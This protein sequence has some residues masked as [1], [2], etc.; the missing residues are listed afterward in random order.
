MYDDIIEKSSL[1]F[2]KAKKIKEHRF[3]FNELLSDLNSSNTMQILLGARGVGKTVLLLQLG[4]AKGNSFYLSADQLKPS[5]D[6]FQIVKG[7]VSTLKLKLILIDEIH[8]NT[9]F[10]KSL[11]AIADFLDVSV[12]VTSSSALTLDSSSIDLSR[13]IRIKY[14][15]PFCYREFLFFKKGVSLPALSLDDLLAGNYSSRYLEYAHYFDDYLRGGLYPFLLREERGLDVFGNILRKI[16]Y[17][18]IATVFQLA[19]SELSHIERLV[20][21]IGK[22]SVDGINITSLSKNLGITKYKA[23][24]YVTALCRT[25]VLIQI[26][27]AGANVL[28]EPKI[29]MS[30]P[31]RQLYLA[32]DLAI[33]GTREDIFALWMKAAGF[34]SLSYLKSTRGE[35]TPD[36]MIED[37]THGP[38]VIEIGGKGKGRSQFKGI[39]HDFKKVVV[40]HAID[41]KKEGRI[42]L[43]MFGYL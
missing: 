15:Y 16:I 43:V 40:S 11:K 34:H 37:S 28:R 32:Y 33:G 24:E 20:A 42:P 29:L 23:D 2:E 8:H 17:K 27:P 5:D 14:I 12:V 18:D 38:I 35:K 19:P 30:P 31:F 6:L 3:I 1:A 21:H 9:N 13:R 39:S 4:I 36:F 26:Y 22:S 25:F 7:L 41:L 10:E